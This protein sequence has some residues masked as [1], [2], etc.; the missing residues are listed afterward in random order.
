MRAAS[1]WP[2]ALAMLLSTAQQGAGALQA[3]LQGAPAAA[4]A[5]STAGESASSGTVTCSAT[6]GAPPIRTAEPVSVP[7]Y[8]LEGKLLVFRQSGILRYACLNAPPQ[9]ATSAGHKWP[10]LVYLHGSITTPE[11]LYLEGHNMLQLH[12]SYV[13][14]GDPQVQGFFILSP[15]GRRATPWSATGPDAPVTGTGFHWDEWYRD[16]ASNLDAAAIDHFVDEVV[17]T[18]KIDP[19][20]IYVF[21]WSNGAY[22]ARLY[23]NWRGDRIAAIGQYTGA[24]PWSRTPCPVPVQATRKVPLILLRN[25]CDALVPCP[26]TATWINTL[27]TLGWPFEYHNLDTAVRITTQAQCAQSCS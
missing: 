10:L 12:N 20:R 26:T 23:G 13:L 16:S 7:L 25:L 5:S 14:S 21:G 17:A 9:S 3:Q 1:A 27:K 2:I 8:C 4:G 15:E 11:S 19:K 22:M 6:T 18:G 24:N